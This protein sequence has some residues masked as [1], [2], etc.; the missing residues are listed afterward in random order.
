VRSTPND[1]PHAK[2]VRMHYFT[3]CREGEEEVC[4]AHRM[5]NH[6]RS[7]CKHECLVMCLSVDRVVNIFRRVS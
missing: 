2:H 4:K 5:T 3:K 7:T 6:V 1:E